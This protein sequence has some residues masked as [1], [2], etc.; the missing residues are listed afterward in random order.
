MNK[1]FAKIQLESL[2]DAVSPPPT[3]YENFEHFKVFVLA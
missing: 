3:L 1:E 2:G